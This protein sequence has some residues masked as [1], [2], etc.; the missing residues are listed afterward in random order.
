MKQ[1]DE[2]VSF[3]EIAPDLGIILKDFV[4]FFKGKEKVTVSRMQAGGGGG[5]GGGWLASV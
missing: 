5:G 2:H 3:R 4:C 1:T